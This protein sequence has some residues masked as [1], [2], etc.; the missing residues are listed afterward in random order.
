MRAHPAVYLSVNDE[1]TKLLSPDIFGDIAQQS[2]DSDQSISDFI[3]SLCLF[4]DDLAEEEEVLEGEQTGNTISLDGSRDK[5]GGVQVLSQLEI[6]RDSYELHSTE[7][8]L[9][10]SHEVEILY[11]VVAVMVSSERMRIKGGYHVDDEVEIPLFDDGDGSSH[12]TRIAS[13]IHTHHNEGT[14]Y[15]PTMASI[16]H[17]NEE[18]NSDDEEINPPT[19]RSAR[20]NVGSSW[21]EASREV[22]AL[23]CLNENSIYPSSYGAV[24]KEKKSS[25]GLRV[26]LIF[27]YQIRNA[28]GGGSKQKSKPKFLF[29][30]RSRKEDLSLVVDDRNGKTSSE[31]SPPP[32]EI[33]AAA[34]EDMDEYIAES[35]LIFR[36]QEFEQPENGTVPFELAQKHDFKEHSMAEFLD[37]FNES[38]NLQQGSSELDIKKRGRK[39]QMVLNRNTTPLGDRNLDEDDPLEALDSGSPFCSDDEGDQQNLK[40]IIPTRTMAD[41]FHEAFG[42]V[43]VVDERPHIAFPRP[44]SSGMYG[45][46]QQVMQSEKERDMDYLKNLSAETGL[47][48]EKM[49]ISVRI[50]TR[51]LEA[52]LIVCS[53]IP[54]D[55]GMISYWEKNLQMIGKGVARTLTII[56][57]PRICSDVELEVGNLICIHPPWYEVEIGRDDVI[58]LCSYFTQV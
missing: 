16:S 8:E 21:S 35:Q 25:K 50:L 10:S 22:E 56:F 29:R 58:I 24:V 46:L 38:S 41:Q 1:R 12:Y 43:S 13:P 3:I 37:C 6:L 20:E 57:N 39:M 45:K 55:D 18:I 48:D 36:D 23:V 31:D 30:L 40:L 4:P 11:L 47:K 42:T 7:K 15:L 32:D 34:D 2:Q 51:S 9:I 28:A 49:C 19:L 27:M 53:C 33:G 5:K 44:L 54:V 52:K 14:I 26:Q 17:S